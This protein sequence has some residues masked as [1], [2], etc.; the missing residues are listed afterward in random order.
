MGAG[1]KSQVPASAVHLCIDMQRIFVED[2][3]W[4]TPWAGRVLPV[5]ENICARK[6]ERTIFTRFIPA[7]RPGEG[8]GTWRAYWERWASMTIEAIG[9]EKVDL[10]LPLQGFAPPARVLDKAGYSPWRDGRLQAALRTS[11]VDTLVVTG[12]ET[13]VCVLAA[14]LGAVDLG[15][16]T[17]V[18]TDALCSSADETHDKII[19]LY[20]DRY[21]QQVET[22][23][24]HELFDAW[25]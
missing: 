1:L 12:A 11:G 22:T 17:I 9:A 3:P 20:N 16:R 23:D 4:L 5:I 8:E 19:D 15:Y 21:G 14:V 2:T 24:S 13:D 18:V 25:R 7:H 6:T 10:A